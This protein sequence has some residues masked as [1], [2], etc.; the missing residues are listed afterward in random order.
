MITGC[1]DL[2]LQCDGAGC[3]HGLDGFAAEFEHTHEHGSTAR[4][5]AR[6]RGW[7]LKRNGQ[8]LCPRCDMRGAN[9]VEILETDACMRDDSTE[10]NCSRCAAGE[11][12]FWRD[13]GEASA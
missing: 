1:Y 13:Q 4:R 6:D 5:A 10:C 7:K 3:S 2:R 9:A 12:E 8:C 11:G